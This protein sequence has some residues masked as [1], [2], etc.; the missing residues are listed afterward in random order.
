MNH[1]LFLCFR[2]MHALSVQLYD[3]ALVAE[4]KPHMAYVPQET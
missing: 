4:L 3:L 2:S 1:F